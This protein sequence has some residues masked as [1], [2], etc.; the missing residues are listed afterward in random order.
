MTD[1]SMM[2]PRPAW[3][4]ERGT[5]PGSVVI[6]LTVVLL[7]LELMVVGFRVSAAH[8]AV[9]NAAREAARKGS[10]VLTA[11]DVEAAL[12]TTASQNLIAAGLRCTNGYESTP[13]GT[14]FVPG[15]HV[16]AEVHCRIDMSDMSS[17]GLPLP[18]LDITAT[19]REVIETYRSTIARLDA[20]DCIGPSC[21][22]PGG[23]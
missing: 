12:T 16:Q 15:G 10:L 11:G 9:N 2:A 7:I 23:P 20:N 17:F 21:Y 4:D 1:L 13:A 3:T 14:N 22:S 8:T 5:S 6:M 19:H 18:N